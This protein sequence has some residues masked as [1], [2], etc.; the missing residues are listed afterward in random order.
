MGV[1]VEEKN[2]GE[3]KKAAEGGGEKTVAPITVVLKL[4]LHCQGCAKK[5]RRS[6][7]HLLGVETVKADCDAKKLT[8][9]GNVDPLWLREKVEI[10][11]NK[12]VELISPQPKKDAASGGAVAGADHKKPDTNKPN[13][14]VV[15]TFTMKTKLH[16]DE[17]ADRIKRIIIKNFDGVDSL[18]TDLQKD[19]IIVTGTMNVNDL[20]TYLREKLKRVEIVPPKKDIDGK[21]NT[22]GGGHESK[23]TVGEG[24]AKQ[25]EAESKLGAAAAGKTKAEM[26]KMEYHS[27]Y[28]PHTHYA[29]PMVMHGQSYGH[30]N[31]GYYGPPPPPPTYLDT[32]TNVN[33]NMFSDENPNGC[34]VM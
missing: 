10:K 5:V 30:T 4:D 22:S 20:V 24:G 27:S 18:T 12:K 1:K 16:C 9:T 3:K 2:E 7:S 28:N 11:T 25:K 14:A 33:D 8:V 23:G 19:L 17:C 26:S 21:Q 34:S 13:K 29:M 32:N 6:V 15:S 31:M